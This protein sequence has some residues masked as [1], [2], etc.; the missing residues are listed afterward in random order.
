MAESSPDELTSLI[1][2]DISHGVFLPECL[3]GGTLADP[4]NG[5]TVLPYA[6]FKPEIRFVGDDFVVFPVAREN[7][8]GVVGVTV[9][10]LSEK[11][12]PVLAAVPWT[13]F[14]TMSVSDFMGYQCIEL[15]DSR[16]FEDD[17]SRLMDAFVTNYPDYRY[18]VYVGRTDVRKYITGDI[19]VGYSGI[20]LNVPVPEGTLYL[21]HGFAYTLIQDGNIM[22]GWP[23]R[24]RDAY[25]FPK[26]NVCVSEETEP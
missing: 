8:V 11:A 18:V 7:G 22:Q 5:I 9:S 24:D 10:G 12:M 2:R 23:L 14:E 19:E 4:G 17:L 16:N 20:R 1:V 3:G 6:K 25:K 13:E 26:K 21:C 15:D